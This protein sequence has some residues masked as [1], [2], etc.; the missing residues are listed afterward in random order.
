M[1]HNDYLL[2]IRKND[3]L[4]Q[5]SNDDYEALNI[6]HNYIVADKNAYIYFDAGNHHKLYFVKEGYVRIGNVDDRGNDLVRE[7]LQ[8]GD[9]FGQITLE[10]AN[11]MQG[12]YA[13][14]HRTGVILCAFTIHD[15]ESLLHR[16]P[17]LAIH[18][19]KKIGLKTRKVENRMLNLLQRDVRTRLLY[20]FWSLIP[21]SATLQNVVKISNYLT[22]EDIARLIATS[23][24]TVTTLVNQFSS[25]G[26]VDM[27]RQTITIHNIKLLQ[28]EANVG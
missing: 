26:L 24:Q 12:E 10:R 18:Y 3:F 4:A 25:E 23:R 20:F 8:P 5:L 22:H 17:D 13:Q 14:A 21:Q 28:K 16:R 9:V 1:D 15:F 6:T 27:D 19:S 2:I 11:H 7:I